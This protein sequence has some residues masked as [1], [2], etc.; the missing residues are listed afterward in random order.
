MNS[1]ILAAGLVIGLLAGCNGSNQDTTASSRLESQQASKSKVTETTEE[2]G[3]Q[4]VIEA[5]RTT[6]ETNSPTQPNF[7]VAEA[8]KLTPVQVKELQPLNNANNR[9]IQR[10]KILVPT[11][12]PPGF[13]IDRFEVS[14][15]KDR[16]IGSD[17]YRSYTIYYK[18]TETNVCFHISGYGFSSG[19]GGD[20]GDYK[21]VEVSSSA[22]GKVILMYTGFSQ[23]RQNS[24]VRFETDYIFV[25][26]HM[27][28]F[29]SSSLECNTI[30]IQE[31]VKIVESFQWLNP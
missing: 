17:Y 23:N 12:L 18:N 30:S 5:K 14:Y 9:N 11:Y 21:T 16:K 20:P 8:A 28:D 3:E 22:L 15:D 24:F 19:G 29:A 13:K 7:S 6:E 2:V 10:F 1:K 27:Y 26:T 25:N 31:A 4:S